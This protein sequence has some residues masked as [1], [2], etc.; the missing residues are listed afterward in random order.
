MCGKDCDC[1]K[2][3]S[4]ES[5]KCE[6]PSA[7]PCNK[8]ARVDYPYV[9]E[10][11]IVPK[12]GAWKLLN[13]LSSSDYKRVL[14]RSRQNAKLVEYIEG[15]GGVVSYWGDVNDASKPLQLKFQGQFTEADFNNSPVQID[16]RD[17]SV[18]AIG[19]IKGYYT[20]A[21]D[22]PVPLTSQVT[23]FVSRIYS[24]NYNKSSKKASKAWANS[25]KTHPIVK[26]P[27]SEFTGKTIG[28][29]VDATTAAIGPE[30][31]PATGTYGFVKTI[32]SF[33]MSTA[34]YGGNFTK[35]FIF[36]NGSTACIANCTYSF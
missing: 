23:N 6:K 18:Y 22:K 1:K 2:E 35:C 10:P 7:T 4:K 31:F 36:C 8:S 28:Q 27:L 33:T 20:D 19:E 26:V 25:D 9:A 29:V 32:T 12:K 15:L 24:S 3:D 30:Q 21:Q 14:D 11:A 16:F 13:T 34:G 5:C 17:N